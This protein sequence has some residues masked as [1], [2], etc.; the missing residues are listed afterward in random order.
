MAVIPVTT[1]RSITPITAPTHDEIFNNMQ[2]IMNQHIKD[3]EELTRAIDEGKK[4]QARDIQH[5][6]R[7]KRD[8]RMHV[9]QIDLAAAEPD[10]LPDAL[11]IPSSNLIPSNDD[12][13]K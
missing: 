13:P 7:M 12:T 10:A 3:Q 2:A 4:A 11:P 5:R 6:L 8:N 1:D 9:S